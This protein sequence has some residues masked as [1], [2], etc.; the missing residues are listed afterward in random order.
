MQHGVPV[1]TANEMRDAEQRAAR[2]G[3]AFDEMMERAGLA[4]ADVVTEYVTPQQG[5]VVVLVGP[6]NNGG[7]GL[8]AARHLTQRGYKVRCYALSKRGPEDLNSSRLAALGVTSVC[9][10]EDRDSSILHEML[11]GSSAVVDAL[12]GTGIHGPLR[13]EAPRILAHVAAFL[14]TR[15]NTQA[16]VPGIVPQAPAHRPLV[17]AVD[18][19]SGLDADTGEIDAATLKADITIT[20]AS[21]KRGH[22]LL[23][24][25]PLAGLV[26]VADI[27]LG[28]LISDEPVY[29]A[30]PLLVRSWLPERIPAGNKGTF[31]SALVVG[32]SINYSGAP[33][34]AAEA[35]YRAG[36]GL[37]SLAIPEG[38]Y[39]AVSSQLPDATYY[40]LPGD[41]RFIGQEQA[42]IAL[43]DLRRYSALLVGPGMG[44]HEQTG[45]FLHS[46]L[47]AGDWA[48]PQEATPP[49]PPTVID[50]DGLNL[51]TK[52][53][54]WWEH[55][56]ADSILT[57][58]PGEM[59]RLCAMSVQEVQAERWHLAREMAV[60]WHCTVVLKGAFTVCASAQGEL[61]VI[62]F[63]NPLLATAGTGDV[64][65]GTI[66][67]LLAQRIPGYHAAVCGAY[68]HGLA[69]ELRRQEIGSAGLLAHELPA[70][71]AQAAKL[72][73][74]E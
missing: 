32:G 16:A 48:S 9:A 46:L 34:L 23:P 30:C 5:A 15:V 55:L 71:V 36:A 35:A 56:P 20:F 31:G 17:F 50:A 19:P 65:A 4:V 22:L 28:D 10:S 70:L 2:S 60:K 64:L 52:L 24:G 7:D 12:F 45:A 26:Y 66:T 53:P 59:A 44:T 1:I 62:P 54:G 11:S 72:I 33:R 3:L 6:G 38:I 41:S 49:L 18:M 68:L 8:V 37:V 43:P 74:Q 47:R 27:G 21:F 73:R 25:G 13:G 57:P 29:A 39:A 40:V 69:G 67:G 14:S 42:C 51:L 63:A 58:H 61:T